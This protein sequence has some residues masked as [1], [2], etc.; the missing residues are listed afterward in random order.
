MLIGILKRRRISTTY[1][2]SYREMIT[3]I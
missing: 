3:T 2:N 1:R